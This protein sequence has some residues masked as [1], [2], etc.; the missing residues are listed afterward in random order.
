[1]APATGLPLKVM[2]REDIGGKEQVSYNSPE[3]LQ[4]RQALARAPYETTGLLPTVA[5]G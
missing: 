3:H 1:M 5:V 4:R 2:V